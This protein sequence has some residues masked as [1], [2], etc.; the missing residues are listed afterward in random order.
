MTLTSPAL[1][2]DPTAVCPDWRE[3]GLCWHG[4]CLEPSLQHT[5]TVQMFNPLLNTAWE[6]GGGGGVEEG[7]VR[8]PPFLA[9]GSFTTSVCCLFQLA[10]CRAVGVPPAS[11]PH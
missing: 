4:D 11:Y 10:T 8:W 3:V 9:P 1:S 6:G 5:D 2:V 7:S